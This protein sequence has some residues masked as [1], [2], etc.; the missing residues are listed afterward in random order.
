MLKLIKLEWE[1]NNIRK[2]I[3]NAGVTAFVLCL[4]MFAFAFLGIAYDPETGVPDA[5]FDT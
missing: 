3:R 4:F 2:Y 1:K 5:A